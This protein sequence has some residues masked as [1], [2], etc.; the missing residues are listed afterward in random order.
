M[1]HFLSSNVADST[2]GTCAVQL[3]WQTCLERIY[4]IRGRIVASIP[5]RHAGDPGSIP[6]RGACYQEKSVLWKLSRREICG[7]HT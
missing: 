1:V 2:T 7:F 3:P 4:S 6:G 5:A